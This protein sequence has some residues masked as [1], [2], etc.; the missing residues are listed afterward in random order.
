VIATNHMVTNARIHP[1]L[2]LPVIAAFVLAGL[3][4]G[5]SGVCDGWID[6]ETR[7][8]FTKGRVVIVS[9]ATEP[10]HFSRMV[11]CRLI[12]GTICLAL[13]FALFRLRRWLEKS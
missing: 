9:K 2:L 13:A 8:L 5:L 12:F 10:D 7:E 6:H 4:F 11:A 3:W 1:A